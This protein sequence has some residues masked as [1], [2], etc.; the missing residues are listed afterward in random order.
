[1]AATLRQIAERLEQDDTAELEGEITLS[2][3]VYPTRE[4]MERWTQTQS[5]PQPEPQVTTYTLQFGKG[6]FSPTLSTEGFR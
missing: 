2:R 1:M 5:Y 3:L 6:A 4:H